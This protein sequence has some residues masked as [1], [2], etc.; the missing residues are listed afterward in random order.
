LTTR[1]AKR[2]LVVYRDRLGP[3]AVDLDTGRRSRVPE[4]AVS[5]L[6]MRGRPGRRRAAFGGNIA[7]ALYAAVT[8]DI[9]FLEDPAEIESYIRTEVLPDARPARFK[10]YRGAASFPLS[11]AVPEDDGAALGRILVARRTSREFSGAPVSFDDLSIVVRAT[12]GQIGWIVTELLGRLVVKTSPSAGATQPMECYILAWNVRGLAKGLWHYDV[13][14]DELRLLRRGDFRR[15][16]VR[17]ASG[18]RWVGEAAFLCVMTAVFRR[19]LWKYR[20]ENALRSVWLEAGH[21]AQTFALAATGCGLGS[22]QTA[23]IQD[24]YAERLLGLDGTREFPVYLL[25][26]GVPRSSPGRAPARSS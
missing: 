20:Y 21:V 10:R 25:G 7:S 14:A 2:D 6:L 24:S 16:A 3:I 13:R 12:W 4:A 9:P 26:A 1:G 11:R 5:S 22:F 8:R 19:T 23:A 15:R 18:Q 17:I